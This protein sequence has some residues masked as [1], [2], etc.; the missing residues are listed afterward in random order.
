MDKRAYERRSYSVP[1]E[2]SYISEGDKF[3]AQSVNHCEEGMCFESQVAFLIGDTLYVRVKDFHPHGPCVGLCEGLRS[4]TLAEVR[5]CHEV[6]D[7]VT[8]HYQVG[9]KFYA[10]V[11]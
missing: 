1:I 3:S 2:I 6:S 8:P 5:W 9:I 7:K 4:M 10:S 11:Y